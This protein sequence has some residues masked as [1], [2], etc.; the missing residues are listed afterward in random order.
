M[1]EYREWHL[2]GAFNALM[3]APVDP[4]RALGELVRAEDAIRSGGRKDWRVRG[5]VLLSVLPTQDADALAVLTLAK[6]IVAK[7]NRPFVANLRAA[8]SQAQTPPA[9]RD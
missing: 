8:R 5:P 2:T 3:L 9:E 7:V 1:F 4:E 6:E